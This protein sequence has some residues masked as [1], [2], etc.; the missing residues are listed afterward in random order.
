MQNFTQQY[1]EKLAEVY[2]ND[3]A[4]MAMSGVLLSAKTKRQ[5][6]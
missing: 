6:I 1:I 5:I 2:R 3:A 4:C